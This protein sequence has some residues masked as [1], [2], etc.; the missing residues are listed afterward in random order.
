MNPIHNPELSLTPPLISLFQPQTAR[1]RLS[2]NEESENRRGSK[3]DRPI[4]VFETAPKWKIEDNNTEIRDGSPKEITGEE[5]EM[6]FLVSEDMELDIARV[7]EKV[8]RFNQ[9]VSDLLDSGKAMFNRLSREFEERVLMI[10]K[11]QIDKLQEEIK[12]L[13]ALDATNEEMNVRLENA[14]CLLQTV[15]GKAD[16]KLG[17][18]YCWEGV[19]E[20]STKPLAVVLLVYNILP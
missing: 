19:A 17:C 4:E 20:L 10:H 18:S 9:Q 11:E 7:F 5:T 12:E 14:K 8:D 2:H 3:S 6:S 15:H 13:R 1:D 16:G